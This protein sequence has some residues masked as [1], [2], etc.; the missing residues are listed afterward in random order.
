MKQRTGGFAPFSFAVKAGG[1]VFVSGQTSRDVR[2]GEQ[3]KGD[4]KVQTKHVLE[5]IKAILE[6]SGSS[7]AD[8]VKTTVFLKNEKDWTEMNE[9]YKQYFPESPPAR[10]TVEISRLV[11][12]RLVEIEAVAIIPDEK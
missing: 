7:M 2:T 1:F 4:V 3:I 5:R 12:D 11:G 10:T 8:V 9:V 6:S